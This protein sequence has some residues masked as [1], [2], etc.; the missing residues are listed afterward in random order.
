MFN[1]LC[2]LHPLCLTGSSTAYK[3]YL[4]GM[5]LILSLGGLCRNTITQ[6]QMEV[7]LGCSLSEKKNEKKEEEE[8]ARASAAQTPMSSH[9]HGLFPPH[10]AHHVM[11]MCGGKPNHDGNNHCR[12][13]VSPPTV[14]THPCTVN[15]YVTRTRI[16]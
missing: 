10:D 9:Q 14:R 12:T 5:K 15:H 2:C 11:Y 7:T 8:E 6:F 3:N 13:V 1:A 4:G 16:K